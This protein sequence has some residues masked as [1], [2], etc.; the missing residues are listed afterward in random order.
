[1]KKIIAIVI[2][3]VLAINAGIVHAADYQATLKRV[4]TLVTTYDPD[5]F[6]RFTAS[7]NTIYAEGFFR[8]AVIEAFYISTST[9]RGIEQ[10]FSRNPDGTF[11]ASFGGVP[12]E[13]NA[14]VILKFADGSVM[15]YRIEYN[16]GWFFGDNGLAAKTAATLENYYTASLI[17]SANYMSAT[18]DS[19]EISQTQALLREIVSEVTAGL[20][21]DYQKAKALNHWVA[22]N[23]VYDRDSRDNDV[24]EETVSIATTLRLRRSVC[25]GIANTYAAL[26]ET[27]GIKALNIKGG[28]ASPMEG[29]PYELLPEKTIVH[30]WVAFWYD[31]ENRW[32]Y[33]DPTW[34]RQGFFENGN[35]QHRPSVIKHFDISALALS[36]DHRGDRAELRQF[37]VDDE[38]REINDEQLADNDE[39]DHTPPVTSPPVITNPPP[40]TTPLAP[41]DPAP[42]YP[43]EDNSL[44][45][46]LIAVMAAVAAALVIAILKYRK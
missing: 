16:N 15:A 29:V 2:F 5:R 39:E 41:F 6:A 22:E 43:T 12:T 36:F 18:L 9:M 40:D 33:T 1:M 42:P 32:V 7:G 35:Y 19:L 30:E 34:D 24:T 37:T 26:L 28:I 4:Y 17:T 11:K 45:I 20:D 31:K 25:I 8:D 21:D 14:R 46:A 44:L 13:K 27:A 3:C 38:Q 10:S 23:I